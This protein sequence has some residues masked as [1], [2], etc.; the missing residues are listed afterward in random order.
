MVLRPHVQAVCASSILRNWALQPGGAEV[1]QAPNCVDAL[2][3]ALAAVS[4][5]NGAAAEELTGNILDVLQQV[6]ER[7]GGCF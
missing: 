7:L 4:H 2:A 6:G 5:D 3:A 1:L